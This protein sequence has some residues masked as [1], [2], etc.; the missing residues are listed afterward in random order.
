M[1]K[2]IIFIITFL[3][4]TSV[5]SGCFFE[6]STTTERTVTVTSITQSHSITT[7]QSTTKQETTIDPVPEDELLPVIPDGKIGVLKEAL[8]MEQIII[9]VESPEY[10]QEIVP[11]DVNH[12]TL[13]LEELMTQPN[14][15]DVLDHLFSDNY[16]YTKDQIG[17]IITPESL[18]VMSNKLNHLPEDYIPSNLVIPEVRA[19]LAEDVDKRYVREDMAK[20]LEGLF[21]AAEAENLYLFCASG[22][23]SYET[24]VATYNYHVNTK[25][26]EE[27]DK[28]SARAGHSEHQTGLAMDVTCEDVEFRLRESLGELPEGLFIAEHAHEYGL[29]V[30]YPNGS[31]PT[32]G[33]SYEPWHL[34]YVGIEFATY[35]YNHQLTLE[36]FYAA[37]QD[38]MYIYTK[39]ER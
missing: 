24:Q 31:F 37:V 32:V 25:G 8:P 17:E 3:L 9:P 19:T 27:A 29:I 33:Y 15:K 30:R 39:E 20:A 2:T 35:L 21:A 5:L 4:V 26:K 6:T 23:R 38:Q 34:R 28:V 18:F 7:T 14:L 36:E 16:N 22:Y 13:S 10:H 12:T 1:K 11:V